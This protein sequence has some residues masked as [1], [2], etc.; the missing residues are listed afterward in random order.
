MQLATTTCLRDDTRRMLQLLEFTGEPTAL[1]SGAA[2]IV[3]MRLLAL[4][5]NLNLPATDG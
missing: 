3:V 5:L 2:T 4:R 1:W